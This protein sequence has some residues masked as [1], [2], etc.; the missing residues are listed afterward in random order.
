MGKYGVT[1][2]ATLDNRSFV[3]FDYIMPLY[4]SPTPV[5]N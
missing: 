4:F 3:G 1:V 5:A 2:E